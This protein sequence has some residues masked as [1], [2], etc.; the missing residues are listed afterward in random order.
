MNRIGFVGVG[1][2]GSRMARRLLAAG[3]D[4]TIHDAV[5]SARDAFAGQARVA[6]RPAACGGQDAVI[7]MVANDAQ[8]SD[9]M[10]GPT[11]VLSGVD[12]TAPPIVAIMSTVLPGT[13]T[14]IA[15][16]AAQKRV[17]LVDAPVSGGLA[18][19]EAGTLSIMVGG[20]GDDLAVLRPV[21]E[22]M[23]K[24]IFHC[25]PLSHG[26]LTKI[27]NNMIGV[28]NLFLTAEVMALARAHGMP[29]ER[30]TEIMDVSSGRN[31]YTGDWN[32]RRR[33]YGAIAADP[34]HLRR[35]MAICRKDLGC[36]VELAKQIGIALPLFAQLTDAISALPQG[37]LG[38]IW[39][40]GFE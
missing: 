28:T 8:L 12:G 17:R 2:M 23:G 34:E 21:F 39:E 24:Q 7:L 25:G 27:L 15:E 32:A 31:A 13:I 30:V 22:T 38:K 10:L 26:V 4:L 19:A 40:K 3:Y 29:A 9:A 35:H 1:A 5:P 16:A 37:S 20:S 18:G 6:D 36:G 33:V 14:A 11:G